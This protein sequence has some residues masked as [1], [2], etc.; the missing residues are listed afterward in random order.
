MDVKVL[1]TS[2]NE[3]K[4]WKQL[5][6]LKEI[7]PSLANCVDLERIKRVATDIPF[8]AENNS[9]FESQ[10]E[11]GRGDVYRLAQRIPVVRA[12]G[13]LN[14]FRLVASEENLENLSPN[15]LILDAL[16]GDGVLVRALKQL[17]PESSIPNILTSDL[18]E[19]MIRGAVEYGIPA[20]WQPAQQLLLKDRSMD[21][22]ILAYG[23]H[24]IPR[25]Q[26]LIVCKEGFR[27][28]KY[29][30]RFVLH[31]F[32]EGSPV[33]RWFKEIVDRYSYTGHDVPH[34][35]REEIASYLIEAE[36][37]SVNVHYV[38]DP[39]IISGKSEPEL[40]KNLSRYLMEMYGL[41]RLKEQ[42]DEE[43][44]LNFIYER[45]KEI[46]QYDYEKVGLD[47]DFGVSK[48]AV[49]EQS[50]KLKIEMPRLAIVGVGIK[51]ST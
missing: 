34:F 25:A 12:I 15:D 37:R 30:G 29:G 17:L 20:L 26:R 45:A 47:K 40:R 39:F 11:G 46:F 27:V 35:T 32:E 4:L 43:N 50:G 7:S 18:S 19:E 36:F 2:A 24:H 23:T 38:Y 44:A 48:I 6:R 49:Y 8:Y 16:G 31:D 21:G 22:V 10:K 41:Y 42:M 3:Q 51:L 13:I 9:D 14:L 1:N 5:A 28:L 33:A